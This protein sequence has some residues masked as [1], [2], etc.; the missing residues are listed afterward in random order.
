M[1]CWTLLA[2]LLLL[3]GVHMAEA[4][5]FA[6]GSYVTDA[7][8]SNEDGRTITFTPTFQADL[9]IVKCN[10]AQ[11]AVFTVSDFG[12]DLSINFSTAEA[13]TANRI[14]SLGN[15]SFTIGTGATVQPASSTCY[16]M[17]LGD[18]GRNDYAADLY[19][20][21]GGDNRDL[22][23]VPP[24]SPEFFFQKITTTAQSPGCFKTSTM[25]GEDC[26]DV[27]AS[28]NDTNEVQAMTATGVTLGTGV[29]ANADTLGVESYVYFALKRRASAVVSGTF[30]G[31]GTTLDITGLGFQP[32]FVLIKGDSTA[33]PFM[34]IA[35]MVGDLSCVLSN[36]VCATGGITAMLPDGFSVG[37]SVSTNGSGVTMQWVAVK[38]P[39][40][41]TKRRPVQVGR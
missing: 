6:T 2:I 10:A 30:V 11:H 32:E 22:P 17:V 26:A 34:R 20:G 21:T 14:Q 27:F 8:P 18:D 39:N 37:A 28:A 12:A 29:T 40:Y 23:I 7:D 16:Y 13:L 5:N 1:R 41:T 36:L 15:G 31:N 4:F 35:S 38:T 9:V 25:S 19:A 3:P 33:V 24:F